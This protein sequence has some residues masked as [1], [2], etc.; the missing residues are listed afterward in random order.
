[1]PIVGKVGSKGSNHN[2]KLSPRDIREI[3]E[4][5]VDEKI[6]YAKL[7]KDYPVDASTIGRIIRKELWADEQSEKAQPQTVAPSI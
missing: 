3:R 6:S 4:R 5:Y 7:A 1:M 2:S